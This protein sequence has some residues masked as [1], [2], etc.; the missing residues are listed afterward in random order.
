MS[1]YF[2]ASSHTKINFQVHT[3]YLKLHEMTYNSLLKDNLYITTLMWRKRRE[4]Q[5]QRKLKRANYVAAAEKSWH[6]L[7]CSIYSCNA[8][9]WSI[10]L[11]TNLTWERDASYLTSS[12]IR[13]YHITSG[14]RLNKEKQQLDSFVG[15]MHYRRR[16]LDVVSKMQSIQQSYHHS[17]VIEDG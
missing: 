13:L 10:E 1:T 11:D 6:V 8:Y 4:I 16:V 2:Y 9:L 12:G 7:A 3:T 17:R 5:M 14:K 15:G